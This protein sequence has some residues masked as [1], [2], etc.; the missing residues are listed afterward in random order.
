MTPVRTER[1]AR[2]AAMDDARPAL[3]RHRPARLPARR[4]GPERRRRWAGA[5]HAAPSSRRS[6]T[7]SPSSSRRARSSSGSAR[8]ASPCWSASVA[9]ARAAGALVVLDVKRGDIGST[10]PGVRR[11]LPRHGLAAGLRRAHRQPV[12]RLRL[13]R[14]DRRDRPREHGAG[15][16]VLALTSNPEGPEVQ[17]AAPP[18]AGRRRRGCSAH[19][20]PSQRRRRAAGLLRGRRRRHPRRPDERPRHQRPA[21][22]ARHRRPGRRRRPTSGGSSGRPSATSCRRARRERCCA[23]VP[24]RGHA[25]RGTAAQRRPALG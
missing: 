12:P 5:V 4:V 2:C 23:T 24:S 19:L 17:H 20:P 1:L 15:L 22:R 21:P 9:E 13:A 10:M 6:P 8:A 18:A 14:P 16:F 3:R 11:R 7:G 25:R